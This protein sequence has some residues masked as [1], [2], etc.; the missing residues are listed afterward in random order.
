MSCEVLIVKPYQNKHNDLKPLLVS[1]GYKVYGPYNGD[2]RIS[3]FIEQTKPQLIL[4]D[5]DPSISTTD[6]MQ[7]DSLKNEFKVPMIY[8]VQADVVEKLLQRIKLSQPY[9]FITR[10]LHPRELYLT[11][12]WALSQHKAENA[13]LI[14]QQ[15]INKLQRELDFFF[16]LADVI[17]SSK[18]SLNDLLKKTA[19]LLPQGFFLQKKVWAAISF[20]QIFYPE[21]SYQ[22]D[23]IWYHTSLTVNKEERGWIAIGFEKKQ[24]HK[25]LKS[26]SGEEKRFISL[27]AERLGRVIERIELRMKLQQNEEFFRQMFEKH[28]AVKLIIDP[29]DGSLL[30]ANEAAVK[31]YGY[32]KEQLNQMNIKD[33]NIFNHKEIQNEMLKA[34][35]HKKSYFLFKHKLSNGQIRDVQVY[36]APIEQSGKTVLLSIIFDITDKMKAEREIQYHANLLQNV[37][38]AIIASDMNFKITSWNKAAE[39]IY[40][41]KL[42]EVLG[43]DVATTLSHYSINDTLQNSIQTLMK[44]SKWEGE[45]LHKNKKGESVYIYASVN[46]IYDEEGK[47]I[48]VVSINRDIT[49]RKLTEDKIKASEKRFKEIFDNSPVG[50]ELYDKKGRLIEVN[51]ACLDIFGVVEKQEL[52]QFNLF[53]DPNIPI[54]IKQR[55]LD[56]DYVEFQSTFD[57]ELVKNLK[58]YQTRKSGIIYLNVVIAPI[59]ED[60]KDSITGYIVSVRDITESYKYNEKL[61]LLTEKAQEANKVKTEFLN[62]ISH[63]L[64]TPLNGI[65]GFTGMMLQEELS[66]EIREYASLVQQS[67]KKLLRIVNDLLDISHLEKGVFSIKKKSFDFKELLYH[68]VKEI[69]PEAQLKQLAFI[70][71]ISENVPDILECDKTRLYQILINLLDNAIKYTKEGYVKLKV[72]CSNQHLSIEVEDSGIGIDPDMINRIFDPFFQVD[73]SHRRESEGTGIG[74]AISK[75]M[76][77]HLDGDIIVNSEVG[78]GSIFTLILPIKIV[79]ETKKEWEEEEKETKVLLSDLS[80]TILVADDNVASLVLFQHLINKKMPKSR[81][82]ISYDGSEALKKLKENKVD[83]VLMDMRMPIMDGFE[84]TRSIR[85]DEQLKQLPILALT[86]YASKEDKERCLTAG[87]NEFLSKPV[88]EKD[89]FDKIAHY[90]LP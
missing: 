40:G 13:N 16:K 7:I 6:L 1:L 17:E 36:S 76:A 37:S 59:F 31:F 43:Q 86:A 46:L 24:D 20:D 14:Q 47:P 81:V 30:H 64:R 34:K 79:R 80:K 69:K 75:Q 53:N 4:T 41:Y 55:L 23:K 15:H 66:D 84:A 90:L 29:S 88:T 54:D 35:S 38:D 8:I 3:T 32:T 61:K 12:E 5:Y 74:L 57:F 44:T 89:L 77:K 70:T 52:Y 28:T 2:Q 68:I 25:I 56:N 33:I 73:S 48:G 87:C 39:I 19:A 63:E 9:H 50:I 51:P 18:S 22:E 60:N 83:L 45:V 65:L 21:G 10:P 62:T 27:V 71:E 72:S 26:L 85:S 67:G 78:K 49:Q 42:E 11:I 82:I 58:L